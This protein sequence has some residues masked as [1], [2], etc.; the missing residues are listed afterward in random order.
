MVIKGCGYRRKTHEICLVHYSGTL[1]LTEFGVKPVSL[2]I[3][4]FNSSGDVRSSIPVQFL[5][6]VWTPNLNTRRRLPYPDWFPENDDDHDDK[7]SS[8]KLKKT[9]RG[10]RAE[11][12]YCSALPVFIGKTPQDQGEIAFSEKLEFVLQ[13]ESQV[14]DITNFAYQGPLGLTCTT[15]DQSGSVTCSWTPTQDQVNKNHQFC[16]DAT[17][18]AGLQTERRCITLKITSDSKVTNIQ[19]M[20]KQVLSNPLSWVDY[21]CAGRG[22]FEAFSKTAGKQVDLADKAFYTWKKCY[23]CASGDDASKVTAYDYSV[24]NDSCG[25]L[26]LHANKN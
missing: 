18:T 23:Q 16:F 26:F 21:G 8:Q 4:D 11:P 5:A 20:V 25:N 19:E 10:R 17:D 1:D 6:T 24:A 3:E 15:V 13:A 14:G 22:N 9:S 2:M 12:S 7:V